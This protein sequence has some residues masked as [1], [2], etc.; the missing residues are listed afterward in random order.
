MH[1]NQ[2]KDTQ[3]QATIGGRVYES[4]FQEEC[5]HAPVSAITLEKV[6]ESVYIYR[7]YGNLEKITIANSLLDFGQKHIH[8][9]THTM[10][11]AD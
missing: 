7:L 3:I 9:Y 10:L 6:K 2:V 4:A 5:A 1:E 8:T 11:C